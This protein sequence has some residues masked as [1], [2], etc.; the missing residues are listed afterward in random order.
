ML[1]LLLVNVAAICTFIVGTVLT[2]ERTTKQG[3]LS[4]ELLDKSAI[5]RASLSV[6]GVVGLNMFAGRTLNTVRR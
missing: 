5:A 1:L 2:T 4:R 3:V 6:P